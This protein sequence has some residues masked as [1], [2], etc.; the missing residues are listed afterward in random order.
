[1]PQPIGFDRLLSAG[2]T[3]TDVAMLRAQFN[4]IHNTHL[5]DPAEVRQMEERWIDESAGQGGELADGTPQGAYEDLFWGVLTGFF[6]PVILIVGIK[7]EGAWGKRRKIA[8]VLGLMM[9]LSF[10]ALKMMS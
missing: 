7:E 9:N 2:F 1:M 6:W 5:L 3:E 10:G 8:I 4:R